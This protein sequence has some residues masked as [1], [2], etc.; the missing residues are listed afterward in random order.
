VALNIKNAETEK[1]ARDLARLR[2]EGI[3]EALTAVLR[4]E[5]ERERKKPRRDDKEKFHR[6]IEEIVQEVKKLPVLD[7]RPADEIL[8]YNEQGHFD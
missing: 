1:L 5:V 7:D 4:R 2:G 3:T 8:G 6:D